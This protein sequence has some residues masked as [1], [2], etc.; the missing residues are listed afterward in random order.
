MSV[1][2]GITGLAQIILPADSDLE[3]V[4]KKLDLD[5]E[6]VRSGTLIL[7]VK[8]AFCTAIKMVGLRSS[9]AANWLGVMKHTTLQNVF[10]TKHAV[11][12]HHQ[13]K[14]GEES[15]ESSQNR[16]RKSVSLNEL[17]QGV[18]ATQK[19]D[20][21]DELPVHEGV[22]ETDRDADLRTEQLAESSG[23]GNTKDPDSGSMGSFPS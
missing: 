13:D 10:H 7:D 2:P 19:V 11:D 5:L 16:E 8:I 3:S 20:S 22:S 4:Q 21:S 9:D 17:V 12:A 18:S 1:K 6:Y 14:V 15:A 23:L